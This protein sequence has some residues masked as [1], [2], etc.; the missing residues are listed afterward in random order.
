KAFSRAAIAVLATVSLGGCGNMLGRLAAVGEAP[1]LTAIENP[2]RSPDY[3]PVSLP[4]PAAVPM[5]PRPN[6]LWRPGSRA[7]FKDQRAARV[8]DI[9]T[10]VINI[11]DSAS[12]SNA[13]DR[14]RTTTEQDA[15]P[16]LLGFETKIQEVLPDGFDPAA[17]LTLSGQTKNNGTGTI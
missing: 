4:M 14:T 17:A 2:T 3:R 12:L 15:F 10:V 16:N 13:T 1:P 6:S 9:L 7:F 8:G 11:D 5:E